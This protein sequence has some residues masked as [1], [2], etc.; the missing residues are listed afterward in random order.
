MKESLLI[1]P[2]K[3]LD[4]KK[5][6]LIKFNPRLRRFFSNSKIYKAQRAKRILTSELDTEDKIAKS[7]WDYW[8][9][10]EFY[11]MGRSKGKNK[12]HNKPVRLCKI[13]IF[14]L[15]NEEYSYQI[16][17]TWRLKQRYSWFYRGN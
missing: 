4:M 17:Q 13:I 15:G 2:I 10:G 12:F 6:S 9:A 8:G 3:I 14:D 11:I 1:Q 5:E 16:S 7:V